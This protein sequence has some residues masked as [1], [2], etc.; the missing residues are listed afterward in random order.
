MPGMSIFSS[1]SSAD[2]LASSFYMTLCYPLVFSYTD[3]SLTTT[4]KSNAALRF[5]SL[6]V[7]NHALSNGTSTRG[8]CLLNLNSKVHLSLFIPK[9][10]SKF[11][12]ALQMC[13]VIKSKKGEQ[14]YLQMLFSPWG[15]SIQ[16]CA[17]GGFENHRGHTMWAKFLFQPFFNALRT[18]CAKWCTLVLSHILI[19]MGA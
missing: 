17:Q 4:C 13:C 5:R 11:P 12:L 3:V 1:P 2:L 10:T 9:P 14:F 6:N 7:K 19:D 8:G 18:E 15:D 16:Y